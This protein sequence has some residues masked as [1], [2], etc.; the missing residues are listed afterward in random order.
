MM[1]K[2]EAD[3][4]EGGGLDRR[5]PQEELLRKE[6]GRFHGLVDSR[7]APAA[8]SIDDEGEFLGVPLRGGGRFIGSVVLDEGPNDANSLLLAE[9][10]DVC[11]A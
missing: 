3:D 10:I 8:V 7:A 11:A 6:R 2:E 9:Q 4:G 1:A 5:F